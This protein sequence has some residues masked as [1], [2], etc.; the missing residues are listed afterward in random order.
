MAAEAV[1]DR[2]PVDD[3]ERRRAGRGG[4]Q[5]V[6]RAV[7]HVGEGPRRAESVRPALDQRGELADQLDGVVVEVG[8]EAPDRALHRHP[9]ERLQLARRLLGRLT[10]QAD[11]RV[12]GPPGGMERDRLLDPERRL[13]GGEPV[14]LVA[15]PGVPEVL[16][17]EHERLGRGVE[18]GDPHDRRAHRHRRADLGVEAELLHIRVLVEPCRTPDG[19]VGRELADNARRTAIRLVPGQ[20]VAGVAAHLAGADQ[21]VEVQLGDLRP[22]GDA[23]IL[24]GIGH[25]DGVDGLRIATQFS[26]HRNPQVVR[27][28][29]ASRESRSA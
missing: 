13:V 14:E 21:P 2:L 27:V 9:V 12:V 1:G 10:E 17:D 16:H 20:A 5:E 28:S 18:L 4:E 22:A 23:G 8:P 19:I 7:V 15:L 25:P 26:R 6:V 3:D 29:A 11:Q 24:E